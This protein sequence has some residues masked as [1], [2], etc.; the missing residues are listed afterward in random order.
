MLIICAL[1]VPTYELEILEREVQNRV[2]YNTVASQS[3]L[4]TAVDGASGTLQRFP[5]RFIPRD[6][7]I[8]THRYSI[9][10]KQLVQTVDA[11]SYFETLSAFSGNDDLFSQL[12]PGPLVANVARTDGTEENVLGYVDA[13][14]EREQ[15]IFFNYDD[16]F[17][18][19]ELPPYPFIC[20]KHSSPES[21]VSYCFTGPNMNNCPQSIIERVNLGL[22]TYT[23]INDDNI[24]TCPGPYTY[25]NRV[26][27]DCTLLGENVEPDFWEE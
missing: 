27:G 12:Q 21:H 15:R 10:V 8:I 13:V 22:S 6:D 17:P 25:V 5:V 3:I 7:F 9:L 11:Y 24:G 1:P 14:S 4:Q 26:C 20:L 16:F 23:G 18:G 19:E 2:C